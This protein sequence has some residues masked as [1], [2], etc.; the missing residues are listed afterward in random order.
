MTNYRLEAYRELEDG[1]VLSAMGYD[2]IVHRRSMG[3]LS[4][5]SGSLV[6]CDLL[7]HPETEPF[8]LQ[9]Q[10]GHYPVR[11][12]IAELR[13]EIAVAYT[14]VELAEQPATRWEVAMVHG[15]AVEEGRAHERRGFAVHSNIAGFMDEETAAL[16]IQYNTLVPDD[17]HELWRDLRAQFKKIRKRHKGKTAAAWAE[18]KHLSI[19][20]GNIMAVSSGLG[21]GLYTTWAG[22]DDQGQLTRLVTDFDVLKL[23]FKSFRPPA[24]AAVGASG[25]VPT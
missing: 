19:G 18:L 10:P 23:R 2:I 17:E 24:A 6:A 7:E 1:E 9:I 22:Y 4:L 8:E 5:P 11:V 21:P 13:D 15:E 16:L 3:A 25:F 14:S 20:Q 12:L